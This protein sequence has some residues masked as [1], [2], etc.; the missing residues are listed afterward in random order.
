MKS[1]IIQTG[2][3]DHTLTG[4]FEIVKKLSD[5]SMAI[6]GKGVLGHP[7]HKPIYLFDNMLNYKITQM[8]YNPVTGALQQAFD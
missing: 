2:T 5:G 3:N 1:L 4:N 7:D 6:N 8:E